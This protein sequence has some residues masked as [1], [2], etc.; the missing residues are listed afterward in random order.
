MME[1]MK[2][3]RPEVALTSSPEDMLMWE[4]RNG[5]GGSQRGPAESIHSPPV[6]SFKYFSLHTPM[7]VQSQHTRMQKRGPRQYLG[8]C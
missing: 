8:D 5:D 6:V 1:I 4:G 3:H 2:I 7:G